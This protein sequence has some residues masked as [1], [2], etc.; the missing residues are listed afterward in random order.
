MPDL[1]ACSF[2]ADSRSVVLQGVLVTGRR[3]PVP[4]LGLGAR[5]DGLELTWC[6]SRVDLL[7]RV[8]CVL[9]QDGVKKSL[10]LMPHPSHR[11]EYVTTN[12]RG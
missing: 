10:G 4:L 6:Q 12:V 2:F 8:A 3:Q 11:E 5:L 7:L 1:F 9:T